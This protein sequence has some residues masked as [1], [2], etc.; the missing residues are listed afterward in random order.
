MVERSYVCACLCQPA[1]RLPRVFH[2]V[3]GL[4]LEKLSNKW[5]LSVRRPSSIILPSNFRTSGRFMVFIRC[6]FLTLVSSNRNLAHSAY[7]FQLHSFSSNSLFFRTYPIFWLPES[8]PFWTFEHVARSSWL[9]PTR[10]L[11]YQSFT[12]DCH[13]IN[14]PCLRVI[15]IF[16]PST[17]H[18]LSSFQTFESPLLSNFH[19][20]SRPY[21]AYHR[22]I[23]SLLIH[24]VLYRAFI[25]R[26]DTP[27]FRLSYP[28]FVRY[29]VWRIKGRG[30][31]AR[32]REKEREREREIEAEKKK[33]KK[34]K[35]RN[36]SNLRNPHDRP[37]E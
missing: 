26:H 14:D 34:G 22:F 32:E 3:I 7:Q 12:I 9:S 17:F 1:T 8:L 19:T 4:A 18:T 28:R 21:L 30:E 33:K 2:E 15:L 36:E 20:K 24:H 29:L 11:A 10:E 25:F 27:V 13:Q 35:K 31:G 16:I 37:R 23:H 6:S 5:P